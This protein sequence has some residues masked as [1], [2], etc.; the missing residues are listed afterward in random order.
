MVYLAST[1]LQQFNGRS[2]EN[3]EFEINVPSS[4][5]RN[6]IVA[7]ATDSNGKGNYKVELSSSFKDEISNYIKNHP[8]LDRWDFLANWKSYFENNPDF[9]KIRPPKAKIQPGR[10]SEALQKQ[11]ADATSMLEVLK[12]IRPFQLTDG[13]IIFRGG[14]SFIAQDGALIV[15]DGQKVGTDAGYLNNISPRDVAN[16]RILVDPIEMATYTSLNTVGVIEITLKKGDYLQKQNEVETAKDDC[17]FAPKPIGN[18]RFG[19]TTT[20]L[21]SPKIITNENGEAT[22]KFVTGKIKS[23]YKIKISGYTDKGEW[24]GTTENIEVK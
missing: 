7:S 14:N 15:I 18:E 11:L 1:S 16:V 19:L 23:G 9:E 24:V 5:E 17:Q 22:V 3:G 20:L 13:K 12:T 21:W 4:L 2:N 8:K 6:N 10:T